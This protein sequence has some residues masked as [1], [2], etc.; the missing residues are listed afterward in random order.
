MARF[1]P[2]LFRVAREIRSGGSQNK[3]HKNRSRVKSRAPVEIPDERNC[4]VRPTPQRDSSHRSTASATPPLS[5][6][7]TT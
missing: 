1:E 5:W 4:C 3:S 2:P 6:L 7:R